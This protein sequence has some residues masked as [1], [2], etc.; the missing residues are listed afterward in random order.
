MKTLTIVVTMFIIFSHA[1]VVQSGNDGIRTLVGDAFPKS[2]LSPPA[3]V[4][5][6]KPVNISFII[7]NSQS[8]PVLNI[9]GTVDIF[10]A[11][12]G[13]PEFRGTFTIGILPPNSEDTLQLLSQ[14]TPGSVALYDVVIGFFATNDGNLSNNQ[15]RFSVQVIAPKNSA[16]NVL[17]AGLGADP[18]SLFTGE[19]FRSEPPDI[20][21]DGPFPLMFSRY[22]A[23]MLKS[24]NNI[25]GTMGDNWLHTY[26]W[27]FSKVDSNVTIVTSKGRVLTF[28]KSGVLWMLTT[29][30]DVPYQ[31]S[32]V[33]G[34]F[35]LLDPS[36]RM[37]YRFAADRLTR[38]E[39]GKGNALTLSYT[40]N[41][42][43]SVADSLGRTFTFSYDAN[44]RLASVTDGTRTI[45]FA[46]TS[47]TLSSVT[48]ARGN[49]WSYTYTTD[50]LMT[51][52]MAPEGNVQYTQTYDSKKRVTT[53]NDAFN[54]TTTI[55]HPVTPG[56][57]TTL[58]DPLGNAFSQTHGTDGL[59]SKHIDENGGAI[60]MSYGANGR[61]TSVRDRLSDETV[62]TYHDPSGY[63]SSVRNAANQTTAF[64][65]TKRTTLSLDFYDLTTINLP[66][67]KSISFAY[68]ANGNRTSATDQKG[69]VTTYTYNTRGQVLT[70]TNSA[71][72]VTT[73]TYHADGM[74]ASVVD[75]A[76][77]TTTFTYDGLKRLTQL[78][79]PD[80]STTK[81]TYDASDNFLT[82][83]DE[84]GQVTTYNYD[85]NNRPTSVQN[86][87][88][89]T[90]AFAYDAM[91]RVTSITDAMGRQ[92]TMSY[93]Q[94]GRIKSI[95]DRTGNTTAYAYDKSGNLNSIIDAA[96][97]KWQRSFDAESIP[98]SATDPLGHASTFA[99]TKLG[100]IDRITSPLSHTTALSYDPMQRITAI[101]DPLNQTS[102]FRYD[103]RGSLTSNALPGD[104]IATAFTRNDLGQPTII[105][106]PRGKNLTLQYDAMGRLLS[107]SDPLGQA[108]Q[109]E[110]DNRNRVKKVTFPAGLGSLDLLYNARYQPTRK[111]YSDGTTIEYAYDNLGRLTSATGVT[112]T[113]DKN[114]RLSGSN[115]ITIERDHQG[116]ITGITYAQNK[117]I[118]YLY[119]TR[120]LLSE[121]TDWLNGKTVYQYDD[122]GRLISMTL[123]NG[124]TT[125]HQYDN[126]DRLIGMQISSLGSI[127]LTRDASGKITLT[128][129]TL[130]LSPTA[131]RTNR[132]FSYN[133]A[134]QVATYAHDAVGRVTNDQTNAYTWN[135]AGRMSSRTESGKT[136][137][138]SYDAFGMRTFIGARNCVWNYATTLPSAA[139]IRDGSVDQS[140]Y[141]YAPGGSLVYRIN[142]SDNVRT[143][144]HFD[145]MG[146]TVF[147]TGESASITAS[148]AY[149]P[150]GEVLGSNGGTG[151]IFT[152]QGQY[153]IMRDS[154]NDLYY[155]R[156]RYYDAKIGRFLSRDPIQSSNP[157]GVN[158]YQ[159]A[160]ENPMLYVDGTGLEPRYPVP[161]PW[162]F[163][164]I[165][166][167]TDV[168]F[169]SAGGG[170]L[171]DKV[172]PTGPIDT[173]PLGDPIWGNTF[174]Y[175]G[176]SGADDD[177]NGYADDTHGWDAIN[178]N[179]TRTDP[180]GS[181]SFNF[182][183]GI[184]LSIG[185]GSNVF[186]P[187]LSGRATNL[188]EKQL[189][190]GTPSI[191]TVFSPAQFALG[192]GILAPIWFGIPI[193]PICIPI[194]ILPTNSSPGTIDAACTNEGDDL[195]PSS[196]LVTLSDIT[197]RVDSQPLTVSGEQ[198]SVRITFFKSPFPPMKSMVSY[199]RPWKPWRY[200]SIPW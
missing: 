101:T 140:Y 199:L 170:A 171:S 155:I 172:D 44:F 141:V 169:G 19:Y 115:G 158:P 88:G 122:A 198:S 146:N 10:R 175:N 23:S 40:G 72:A 36:R 165:I 54:N 83:T 187:I 51:G 38:I 17:N 105:Q 35:L 31:L 134:S 179:S 147:T 145:E 162:V 14:W 34:E 48:D 188:G 18:V 112:F 143:Y 91:D 21:L 168:D 95:T 177:G 6:G 125:T 25:T 103:E 117:K 13:F 174:E 87:L 195:P 29:S 148:F 142:A 178:G 193:P 126:D 116:R 74:P 94:L 92:S 58:T 86:A 80:A 67:G 98:T 12:D 164:P 186:A 75:H 194:L 1:T 104:S 144:Y 131:K 160:Y 16:A 3:T 70:T 163:G 71:G 129:K 37:I 66:D 149:S 46:Y 41:K 5:V 79:H 15:K 57:V 8:D 106:D 69:K 130:P 22:Y 73:F 132:Q 99:S 52:A 100:R 63:I 55:A 59:V 118:A 166:T 85:K 33:S 49:A 9:S 62:R 68:D 107:L 45:Q 182:K 151:E 191:N 97:K 96:G 43:S 65:Y 108:T 4:P 135:L 190:K 127:T 154:D 24:D 60:D 150:Y 27:K 120:G 26:E 121:I 197:P 189:S 93:D 111:T 180:G 176:T 7:A 64:T 200:K 181:P 161:S 47:N 133:D 136:V 184:L 11:S 138:H 157:R 90:T 89:N 42:L 137:N 2:L 50:T 159:Y 185:N 156:A 152:Y 124:M 81:Y 167:E 78:T 82:M 123:P 28:K 183:G 153:G 39:D 102:A 110:Y 76:G 109:Y 56:G 77:N 119:N 128:Q 196:P 32:E 30:G 114:N 84:L 192:S 20:V 139:I 53:Q 113:Y 173:N 61:L